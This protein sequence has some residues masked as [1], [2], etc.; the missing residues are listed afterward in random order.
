VKS[1]ALE[2]CGVNSGVIADCGGTKKI[3]HRTRKIKMRQLSM[4]LWLWS[5]IFEKYV[6]EKI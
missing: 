3:K 4:C 1:G 5:Q 2:D 6:V